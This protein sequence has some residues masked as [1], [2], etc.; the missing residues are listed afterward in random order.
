MRF[1][2]AFLILVLAVACLGLD[3]ADARPVEGSRTL[4]LGVN[5]FSCISTTEEICDS[6]G[7][8]C[9]DTGKRTYWD[10]GLGLDGGYMLSDMLE[11]GLGAAIVRT[12]EDWDPEGSYGDTK[13][14]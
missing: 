7:D 11:I 14:S 5:R 9:D 13:E 2:F 10:L 12:T 4:N 8:N 6:D 3:R 1:I